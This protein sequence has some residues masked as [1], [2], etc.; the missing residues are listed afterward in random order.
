MA[1]TNT[2][3]LVMAAEV[4]S[5]ALPLPRQQAPVL[6]PPKPAEAIP[7]RDYQAPIAPDISWRQQ[8]YV[9]SAVL[10]I[11]SIVWLADGMFT[12][13]GLLMS[14]IPATVL[15]FILACGFHLLASWGQ[16][17]LIFDPLPLLKAVGL[18]LLGINVL[19]NIVG[20]RLAFAALAP[21]MAGTLPM[22]PGEWL[23]AL[24]D[25]AGGAL[26]GKDAAMPAWWPTALIIA[27][28]GGSLA[29]FAE[30]LLAQVHTRWKVICEQRPR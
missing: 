6:S 27:L 14:G 7:A 5:A 28:L 9:Y 19:S 25:W 21:R 13:L 16:R 12:V 17:S 23:L 29:W 11:F 24:L 26:T 30:K 2:P 22:Y 8:F 15:G 4:A 3:P 10:A 1:P 20:I 18:A